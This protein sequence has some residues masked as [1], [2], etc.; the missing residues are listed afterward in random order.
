MLRNKHFSIFFVLIAPTFF[1]G[2]SLAPDYQRPEMP[3]AAEWATAPA[4]TT[5]TVA[6]RS[7]SDLGWQNFFADPHLQAIISKA[8]INNRD[9][10]ESALNV[11]S[12][13]AQYRIQRSALLP[14]ISANGEYAKQRTLSGQ[15]YVTGEAY[16]LDVGTT[17]YEID[18]FGRVRNLNE[19]ALEQYLSMEATQKSS[20]ISLVAEVARAYLTL[21]ADR[22]LLALTEQTCASEQASYDLIQKRFNEGIATQ[23]DLAQ[24]QTSLQT[25]KANQAQYRRQVEQDINQLTLLAGSPVNDLLPR[26][27]ALNSQELICPLP[28]QLSSTVLLQR[29]DIM[30]AEH[31]LKGT[32]AN[33]GAARAA[34][35]PTIGLTAKA[36]VLSTEMDQLF[37]GSSGTWLFAPTITVPLFTG[38]KLQ[39]ELDVAE[40][41]KD[42]A[43]ARYDKAIQTAF[44]ETADALAGIATYA[45][46]V[47][48]RVTGLQANQDYYNLAKNR[49][50]QGVD[51]YLV[52]LDAQRSLYNA[53]EAAV[54]VKLAQLVN[55]VNLYKALGG[56]W[57][58]QL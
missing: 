31:D 56:G 16:S 50:E 51:S 14:A 24:A 35:F 34:F 21:L 40:I 28:A 45:E 29:P 25:A 20:H 37:D 33:I 38:G 26:E 22:E 9:L 57:K 19:Q 23:I 55:Q 17:S 47:Q 39:A 41:R 53:R 46:Q 7:A 18:F 43:I 8:L 48:A 54:S 6:A 49:Y 1:Q 27:S 10:R 12:Y 3:V 44:R 58:A 32:N 30:A 4:Q 13:Q 42:I 36:G 15:Y 5:A 2:C 11:Q 52:L